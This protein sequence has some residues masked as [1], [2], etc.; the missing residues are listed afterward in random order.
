MG[1]I[2]LRHRRATVRSIRAS[3]LAPEEKE[4]LRAHAQYE[5]SPLHKRNPGDFGL[6]PPSAPRADKTLCDEAHV[7]QVQVA[8]DLLL[9]A[10]DG[11]I[12]SE[13]TA[14][15][16]FP[17]QLWVVDSTGQVFEAMHGGSQT[18]RYHGYPIRRTDPLFDEIVTAWNRRNERS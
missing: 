9:S 18:G 3:L 15:P 17:K 11:G 12:V 7:F 2:A 5:G 10:I 14:S 4:F 16:G 1:K 13:G 8:K 6:T